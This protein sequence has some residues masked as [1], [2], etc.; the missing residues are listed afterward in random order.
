[1]KNQVISVS[2]LLDRKK[3]NTSR[4][5][6]FEFFNDDGTE[7]N[8]TGVLAFLQFRAGD[9]NGYVKGDF[10]I[11]TGLTWVSESLGQ[12]RLDQIINLNFPVET[13]YYDV[14]LKFADGSINTYVR[15]TMNVIPII[16]KTS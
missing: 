5:V 13:Y 8:M 3:G 16:T 4:P 7:K 6:L 15:G 10:S 2:N 12:L 14:R 11:G 1:M 9:P